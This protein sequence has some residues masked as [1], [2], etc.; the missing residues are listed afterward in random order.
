VNHSIFWT[1]LAPAGHGGGGA[2]SGALASA[3]DAKWGS[4]E[5]FKTDFVAKAMG[6]QVRNI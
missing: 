2:P 3:I 4:F 5:A 6:I 1:N